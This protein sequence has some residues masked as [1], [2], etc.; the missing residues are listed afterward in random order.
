MPQLANGEAPG[1]VGI[2]HCV[3]SLDERHRDYCS[4]IC[5]MGAFKL[6]QLVAHKLP[7]TRVTH[8]YKT[9]AVAGK[10][11]AR[12]YR[13]AACSAGTELVQF[14][15]IDDLAVTAADD[16]WAQVVC[17]GSVRTHDLV[18]LMPAMVPSDGVRQLSKVLEVP[19]D[20]NG[21][22]DEMHDRVSATASKIRGIY[23]A[24]ACHAPMDL[25][26]AMTQG[27]AAAGA[28]LAALVPGRQL[29]LEPVHAS[30][31]AA[32][33]SACYRCVGVCPYKAISGGAGA[34]ARVDA[35]LCTGC[36]TCVATC[37]TGAMRG[38]HFN[39]EQIYA[40]I[41]GALA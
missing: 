21:Y 7:G 4:G 6:N 10:H 27:V 39:D 33:C 24:G 12:L 34:K 14:S 16:G 18:V 28:A 17:R 22:F 35:A 36:G 5:C 3:G 15:D 38:A 41:E 32:T 2:V 9:L 19:L 26:Q 30:V 13:Q 11:E 31:E 1:D 8:Y 25:G 23:L 20:A 29:Q 40:E 37:P